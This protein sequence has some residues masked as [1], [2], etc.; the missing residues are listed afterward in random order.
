MD[1]TFNQY[2]ANPMNSAVMTA[3][4]REAMRTNYINK[5][6]AVLMREHSN[7]NYHLYRDEDKN[8]YYAYFK[9]PSETI[10]NLYY[11]TVIEFYT[12]NDVAGAG[13]DL[14]SYYVRFYSN[15]PGFV[16]TYAHSFAKN[17]LLIRE[18]DRK[19][20]KKA[21]RDA[22]KV[23][24]PSNQVGY[25]KTIYFVYLYMKLRSLNKKSTFVAFSTINNVRNISANVVAADVKISEREAA[26]E[27]LAAK[28]RKAKEKARQTESDNIKSSATV[29]SNS[30][31]IKK[32]KTVGAVS[33]N[34]KTTTKTKRK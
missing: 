1:I 23:K 13:E 33:K 16:Y 5:F 30:T 8:L 4:M 19:M 22:A 29:Q 9:V 24:N 12:D 2:I 25:V 26:G 28:K 11:D 21:L 3:T 17:G 31:K 34:V 18:F 32:T 15:D 27:K 14:F 10:E 6:N 7:F 20:S